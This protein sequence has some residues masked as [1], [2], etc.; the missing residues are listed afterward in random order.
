MLTKAGA[1]LLDFG[2]AKLKP[3][4]GDV[5][6]SGLPTQSAGL[7]GE[8]AILGTLQ[9][10]APEQLEGKEADARTDIFAFGATVY[11]AI[12]GEKTFS[13]KSQASLIGSI[14]RD[15]PRALSQ[16]QPVSPPALDRVVKKCL[17]KD[18][19]RRW[20]SAHDLHDELTWVAEA[21]ADAVAAAAPSPSQPAGRRQVASLVAAAVVAGALVG[22]AVWG[23]MRA[24]PLG[25]RL[26]TRVAVT[27]PSEVEM[28]P[29]LGFA[30]SPGGRTVVFVGTVG[31]GR[32][33]LYRRSIGEV[34]AVPIP[35]TEQPW[36]PF[37]SPD[38]EWAGYIDQGDDTLKRIRLDGSSNPVTVCP[39]PGGWRSASWGADDL[40]VFGSRQDGVWRVSANGGE[41][42]LIRP[43]EP[44]NDATPRWLDVL[45]DGQAALAAVGRTPDVEIVLLDVATGAQT[46][47]LAGTSPRYVQTGH[48]VY[49][50]EESLW[51]VPFDAERHALTGS[52]VPVVEDVYM[53]DGGADGLALFAVGGNSLVYA[54]SESV[55]AVRQLV[56]VDRD[57]RVDPIA[58]E[59]RD[60]V[61]LRLSPDGQ[62]AAVVVGEALDEDLFIYDLARDTPTRLTF[63]RASDNFPLWSPDG[64]RVLFASTRAGVRNVF[65]KAADGTGEVTRLTTSDTPQYPSSLAPDGETLVLVEQRAGTGFDLSVLPTSGEGAAEPLLQTEFAEYQSAISPNG[66]WI[67]YASTESGENHVYVRPFPNV[68]DGQWQVSRESGAFPVWSPDGRELFYPRVSD[69]ALMAVQVETDSTFS[70]GNPELRFDGEEFFGGTGARPFDIAPDGRFLAIRQQT[71]D[72][73]LVVVVENW[74]DELQRLV[75]TP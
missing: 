31:G 43:A 58:A 63:D 55:G 57:G 38:G 10:M 3:V 42:E 45:P 47:L 21:G 24:E 62:R 46:P 60:Y 66:R 19:E 29:G 39:A 67:A 53:G 17:A 70:H 16:L 73:S 6:V 18:P 11:E 33:Q 12:T 61:A 27:A 36:V 4:G 64:E 68:N 28:I 2:L 5:G 34:G 9:Y 56:W 1:K 44:V 52:P 54:P 25:P 30:L 26:A 65:W 32:N 7:T 48:I 13:G 69:Q 49:W 50:R 37:F 15:Q 74:L 75:P 20:H 72:S 51:A 59:P 14:L 8:G 40:I 41:P 71:S 23:L 35:G 22:L